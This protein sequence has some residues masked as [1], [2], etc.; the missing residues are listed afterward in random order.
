MET[1][2]AGEAAAQG[3]A[4]DLYGIDFTAPYAGEKTVL[5]TMVAD[6]VEV[7][8][9]EIDSGLGGQGYLVETTDGQICEFATVFPL[10]PGIEIPEA[11]GLVQEMRAAAEAQYGAPSEATGPEDT[12]SEFTWQA[13]RGGERLPKGVAMLRIALGWAGDVPVVA[14]LKANH[15]RCA[16]IMALGLP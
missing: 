1:L 15:Q 14:T 2:L 3:R 11:L 4:L 5:D 13:G 16:G 10:E 9:H 8:L 7:V 6:G 12:P